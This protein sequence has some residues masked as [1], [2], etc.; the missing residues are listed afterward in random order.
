MSEVLA[1]GRPDFFGK[2]SFT[3]FIGIVEDVNDPTHSAR[4]KVRCVGWHPK[5]NKGN[6]DQSMTTEDLPWARV[7]MPTTHAQGSRMG[8]K[9]GLLPGCWVMGFFIDGDEAQD[10]FVLCSFNMTSKASERDNRKQVE[11]K[12]G[13]FGED[14][15]GFD[16]VMLSPETSKGNFAQRT[17]REPAQPGT[18]D[19]NDPAGDNVNNDSDSECGGRQALMSAANNE[20]INGEFSLQKPTALKE[21]VMIA[22][23]KCGT[24]Q[25]G[26]E[27]VNIK[28]QEKF[29]A[30]INRFT[31]GDAVWERYQGNFINLQGII[32]SL[33][34]DICQLLKAIIEA[35][36]AEKEDRINRTTMSAG[37]KAALD[38]DG[39]LKVQTYETQKKKDDMFHA[40]IAKI[41]DLLCSIIANELRR[42]NNDGGQGDN[43][44]GGGGRNRGGGGADENTNINDPG[45]PCL[46]EQIINNVLIEVEKGMD[47]ALEEASKRV[48]EDE[49]NGTSS[50]QSPN[51]IASILGAISMLF[52]LT[53]K[54]TQRTDVHNS[55]GDASQDKANREGC[56]QERYY[57]TEEGAGM[58][59]GLS[60]ALSIAG[61][62][63]SQDGQGGQGGADGGG[64][65][66]GD[67]DQGSKSENT[68]ENRLKGYS[69][70]KYGGLNGDKLSKEYD[71][72][73]CEDSKT[74][75]EKIPPVDQLGDIYIEGPCNVYAGKKYTFKVKNTGPAKIEDSY[76]VVLKRF[77]PAND[78][79]WS[80]DYAD[81]KNYNKKD[82]AE[83]VFERGPIW[84][85]KNI[86]IVYAYVWA[87]KNPIKKTFMRKK[88]KK[89]IEVFP[90]GFRIL[91]LPCPP[92]DQFDPED[93]EQT[94]V[95]N[96]IPI[97]LKPVPD[98]RDKGPK[99]PGSQEPGSQEPGSKEPTRGRLPIR[100]GSPTQPSTPG[101]I[102]DESDPP[103]NQ[104]PPEGYNAEL[105]PLPLPSEDPICARNFVNG[106]PN[107]V[108]VTNTGQ[109][110][111]YD[112]PIDAQNAFPSVYI[113]GYLG[114]PVPVVDRSS[115]EIVAILTQCEAWDP[116]FPL[117]PVVI[118]PAPSPI[119]YV[120]EDPNIDLFVS[121]FFVQNT[122]FQ[123]CQPE[124]RLYDRDKEAYSDAQV[125]PILKQGRIVGVNIESI[126]TG[127]RR[128]PRVDI[129]DDGSFCNNTGGYGANIKPIM[130]V[131]A[132]TQA[133]ADRLRYVQSIYCPSKDMLNRFTLARDTGDMV[134]DIVRGTNTATFVE[135]V[136][137]DT[138]VETL[139]TSVTITS[140]DASTITPSP[141][142]AP[143]PYVPSSPVPTPSTDSTPTPVPQP[144]PTPIPTPTPP[145][146]TPSPTPPPD[147][148]PYY[149]GGG[150]Y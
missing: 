115:G 12:D 89:K 147:P 149:G 10:P 6:G 17:I 21:N 133:Y 143:T 56:K 39:D 27:D 24:N 98:E 69:R 146:P 108:V 78:A 77:G 85:T 66:A 79:E 142:P 41:I 30:E 31:F 38:R 96:P 88:A 107:T 49:E 139:D 136:V 83:I 29:P 60:T 109:N 61:Q 75:K 32:A 3:P 37:I 90:Q 64:G 141:I 144:S 102:I 5:E 128:I 116:N 9:H 57:N 137:V 87:E 63:A 52:S 122:G 81:V 59:L 18:S 53:E 47:E 70:I 58:A 11:S 119:G 13:K 50:N 148:T 80:T 4:V 94:P 33:S 40:M 55:Q 126:G 8:G 43:D 93:P 68:K 36:K 71:D 104:V 34:L 23:G 101:V 140:T 35:M 7:G 105:N 19:P 135:P 118:K 15:E 44:G 121:G 82:K 84:E 91:D 16:K 73:N 106:T 26:A 112:N 28:M 99:D 92:D 42:R 20:A 62:L 67:T 131:I 2:D 51:S 76:F 103:E 72:T 48:D 110:Y 134:R 14:Y 127:F 123:Y 145:A 125:S 46:T 114:T 124:I 100:G 130:G 25:N 22:D 129:F 95:D 138:T 97:P 1:A 74:P 86:M 120:T 150:G 117:P 65:D 111:F 132:K 45:A 113:P 54:Y